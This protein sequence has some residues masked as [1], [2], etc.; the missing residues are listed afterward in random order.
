MKYSLREI[1]RIFS[2][3]ARNLKLWKMA[4]LL[5]YGF[6]EGWY[7]LNYNSNELKRSSKIFFSVSERHRWA[8][9]GKA[10]R[11][12]LSNEQQKRCY[13]QH[14]VFVHTCKYG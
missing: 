3:K 5:N 11:R 10:V 13:Q 6:Q 7:F 8:L 4:K 2:T 14:C 9:V 12:T 1:V